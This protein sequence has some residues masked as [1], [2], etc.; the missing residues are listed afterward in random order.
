MGG[1]FWGGKQYASHII[2]IFN[3]LYYGDGPK[4]LA[5]NLFPRK[6]TGNWMIVGAYDRGFWGNFKLLQNFIYFVVQTSLFLT[7]YPFFCSVNCFFTFS[8]SSI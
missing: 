6:E 1:L 8:G 4:V 2:N 5:N 7:V 3:P